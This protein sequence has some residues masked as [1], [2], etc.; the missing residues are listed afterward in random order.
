[1][2]PMSAFLFSQFFACASR[3]LAEAGNQLVG[4]VEYDA[5]RFGRNCQ[6]TNSYRRSSAWFSRLSGVSSEGRHLNS[7]GSVAARRFEAFAST[8]KQFSVW[9]PYKKVNSCPPTSC[10]FAWRLR[11]CLAGAS[12]LWSSSL[13]SSPS[14]LPNTSL[15]LSANGMPPG[16]GHSAV[17][18]IL[19]PGPGGIPL[20]PA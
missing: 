11:S 17:R 14:V 4:R 19:W 3:R 2:Q 1:M 15:K 18:S 20:S 16:P 12:T 9:P 10:F 8:K 6:K 13:C 7:F 5:Q